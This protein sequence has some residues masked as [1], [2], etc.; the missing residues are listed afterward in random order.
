VTN[1]LHSQHYCSQY[2][3]LSTMFPSI[4][5]LL[6]CLGDKP[7][8]L[9]TLLIN[10]CNPFD[11]FHVYIGFCVYYFE[12]GVPIT[13]VINIHCSMIILG[14]NYRA[15]MFHSHIYG[16]CL[17]I[18]NFIY[19]LYIHNFQCCHYTDTLIIVI[20]FALGILFI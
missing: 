10:L 3:E 20:V 11:L 8:T 1:L 15:H 6:I 18:T 16:I 2:R 7:S 17:V 12:K 13:V 9:P 14:T 19:F 4:C 5:S